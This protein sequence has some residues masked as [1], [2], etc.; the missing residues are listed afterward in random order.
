[1]MD[2]PEKEYRR[3]ARRHSDGWQVNWSLIAGV[4]VYLAVCSMMVWVMV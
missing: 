4:I 1:M 2:M 3:L